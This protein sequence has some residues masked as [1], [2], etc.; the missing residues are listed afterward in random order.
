VQH[1]LVDAARVA[2]AHLD[3]CRM[4][5]DVDGARIDLEEQQ[6]RRLALAVQ[7]FAIGPRTACE[8]IR[9]R[10]KRPFTNRYCASA[11]AQFPI[12]RGLA[13]ARNAEAQA[14]RLR[15]DWKACFENS[16]PSSAAA[17]S[18]SVCARRCAQ[19]RPLCF[20]VKAIS[21]RA[22][23]MRRNTSSQ[24]PNSVCSVRMNFLRAGVL[25]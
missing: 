4:D 5:I 23:A 8:S 1:E 14:A 17:R 19:T 25:K 7:Q 16:G 13:R 21:G 24:C 11:R 20:S 2:E 9:S 15:F 6:V 10:T 12:T 18:P 3:L 22:R